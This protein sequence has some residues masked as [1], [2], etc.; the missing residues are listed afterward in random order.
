M[1]NWTFAILPEREEAAEVEYV[2]VYPTFGKLH[3]TDEGLNC[4]CQPF[5]EEDGV[6]VHNIEH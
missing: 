2:H 3:K 5:L 1:K 4:W 6:I